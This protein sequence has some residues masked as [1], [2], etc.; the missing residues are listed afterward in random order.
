MSVSHAPDPMDLLTLC[1]T[2]KGNADALAEGI[3][4]EW[5]LIA[6]SE[7]WHA[8]PSGLDFDHLPGM[9]RALAG[10]ALCTE[11]DRGVCRRLVDLAAEHGHHR[12]QEGFSESLLFREYH[13]LRRALWS[14]IRQDHGESRTVYYAAMRLDAVMSLATESALH[15]L[16]RESIERRGEWPEVLDRLLDEWPLPE[17]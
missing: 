9:I 4:S 12:A 7:P 10:A 14:R 1:E 5:Q 16:N 13:L 3:V 15:G 8:L 17:R 6:D 11:F 2:L